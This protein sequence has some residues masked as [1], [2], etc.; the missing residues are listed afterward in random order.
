VRHSDGHLRVGGLLAGWDR[1]EI[2]AVSE[3]MRW[4]QARV[5]D[6]G[7]FVAAIA[8]NIDGAVRAVGDDA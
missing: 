8:C 7:L 5:D 1:T 3:N 2:V 6:S 4:T